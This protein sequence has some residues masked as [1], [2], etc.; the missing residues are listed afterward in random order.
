MSIPTNTSPPGTPSPPQGRWV[1]TY[2]EAS[3]QAGY[4]R[5]N[6]SLLS[7]QRNAIR[8]ALNLAST[9]VGGA[10]LESSYLSGAYYDEFLTRAGYWEDDFNRICQKF[11]FFLTEL[12]TLINEAESM[13]SLWEGRISVRH[14][15]EG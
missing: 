9:R 10:D 15:V 1:Y 3:S 12:D 6:A 8:S 5:H 11:E 14:W 13:E 2:P 7:T 4:F